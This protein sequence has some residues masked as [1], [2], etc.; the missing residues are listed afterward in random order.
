M[1]S[2][3]MRKLGDASLPNNC[4]I[5]LA[6]TN[7]FPQRTIRPIV[8]LLSFDSGG[9]TLDQTNTYFDI[10]MPGK[11]QN[12]E[13]YLGATCSKIAKIYVYQAYDPD[14]TSYAVKGAYHPLTGVHQVVFTFGP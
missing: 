1:A 5:G 7:L 10:I 3:S 4:R 13:I 14:M 9:N 12:K 8:T 2:L 6:L 11:Q